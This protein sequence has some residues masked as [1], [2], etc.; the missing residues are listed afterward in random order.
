MFVEFPSLCTVFCNCANPIHIY[1]R[2]FRFSFKTF[3]RY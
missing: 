2:Y 1:R 3:S